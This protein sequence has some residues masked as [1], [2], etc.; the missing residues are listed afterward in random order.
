MT[1]TKI[2]L[3][4]FTVFENIDIKLSPGI[5][6]FIGENGTGKTHLLKVAHAA[7]NI[8]KTKA[9]FG[10]TLAYVF[11]PHSP[12]INQLIHQTNKGIYTNIKIQREDTELQSS[13]N[14]HIKEPHLVHVTNSV[15]WMAKEIKSVYISAY[16][17]SPFDY[18]CKDNLLNPLKHRPRRLLHIIREDIQGDIIYKEG[19]FFLI[20]KEKELEFALLAGGTRKLGLLWVFIQR[21]ILTNG[22]VLF[23]DE[24]EASLSP[25]RIGTLVKVLLELQRMGVQILLA[26]HSYVLL[27]EFDLQ[28]KGND[29]VRFHTLYYKDGRVQHQSTE[30][31]LAIYPNAIADAFLELYNRDVSRALSISP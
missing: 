4:W 23:W 8:T 7:C 30:E 29:Q 10:D 3:E 28:M 2:N 18:P 21:G 12:R 9:N 1:L 20:N 24:P 22:S 27:K 25:R 31:F 19:T 5:N 15:A 14:G 6:I 26:T 11:F 13:F 17:Y 16:Q